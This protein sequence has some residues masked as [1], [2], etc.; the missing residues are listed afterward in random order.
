MMYVIRDLLYWFVDSNIPFASNHVCLCL[1]LPRRVER[2][3]TSLCVQC[4]FAGCNRIAVISC[5]TLMREHSLS[6]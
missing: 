6:M 2:N 5:G 3:K 4:F 1:V